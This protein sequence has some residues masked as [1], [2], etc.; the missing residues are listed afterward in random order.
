MN[1]S[2]IVIIVGCGIGKQTCAM[3]FRSLMIQKDINVERHEVDERHPRGI[4]AA[5]NGL[6]AV[7]L[8]VGRTS[9]GCAIGQLIA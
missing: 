7:L 4:V 6:C 2:V 8:R 9:A 5:S 1:V 3:V